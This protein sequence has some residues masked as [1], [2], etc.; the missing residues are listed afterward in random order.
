MNPSIPVHCCDNI[1]SSCGVEV[2]IDKVLELG[3]ECRISY[4]SLGVLMDVFAEHFLHG[5]ITN[6][7]LN[8]PKELEAL[9]VRHGGE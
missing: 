9:L 6:E 5:T 8:V 3:L 1:S 2:S 7:A 4:R